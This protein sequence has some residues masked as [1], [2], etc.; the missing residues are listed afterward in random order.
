M[1]F[2]KNVKIS[3]IFI[4]TLPIEY[5]ERT[6]FTRKTKFRY[7]RNILSIKD[8]FPFT[9]FRKGINTFHLNI[10]GIKGVH[11]IPEAINWIKESYCP[12]KEFTLLSHSVDNITSSFHIGHKL[13][14]RKIGESIKCAKFN[15]ERFP[16]LH[17]R[18][19]LASAVIFNSGY[20]NILGCKSEKDV[21]LAWQ[22]IQMK[23][24]AA[25]MK[26][27]Q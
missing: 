17:L 7:A 2:I 8:S 1:S 3:A 18:T 11:Q 23:L 16:G 26:S 14:L 5:F 19:S 10:T 21:L 27:T 4:S 24:S 6:A 15:P 9:I 13:C 22:H 12:T 20:I 25:E